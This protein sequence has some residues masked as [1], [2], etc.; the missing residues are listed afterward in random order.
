MKKCNFNFAIFHGASFDSCDLSN[1]D[2]SN[3]FNED[4]EDRVCPD[5]PFYGSGTFINS[6]LTGAKF[7][8]AQIHGCSFINSIICDANFEN[9]QLVGCDFTGA[10]ISKTNFKNADLSG[11]TI[12]IL[13]LYDSDLSGAVLPDGRI[14]E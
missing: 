11:A 1:S 13:E 6:D 4:P 10:K 14:Y 3:T 5:D 2:F 7:K 9:A 8:H 12:D